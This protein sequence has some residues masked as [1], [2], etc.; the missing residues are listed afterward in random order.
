MFSRV[1]ETNRGAP[2]EDRMAKS[3][4]KLFTG[5]A[6]A[7]SML[8]GSTASAAELPSQAVNPWGV[9]SAM[10]GGAP[11][12]AVCGSAAAATAVPVN[13]CV[14]PAADVPAIPPQANAPMAVAPAGMVGGYGVTP[15]ILGL[16]A[17]AAGVGF[18]FLVKGHDHGNVVPTSPD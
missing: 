13:G 1:A 8:L 16:L 3:P 9:L 6:A 11:T 5:L 12:A 14:L 17:L 18:L 4:L 15:M 7:T 2:G 10:S